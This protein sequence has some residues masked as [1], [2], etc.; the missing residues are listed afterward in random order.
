MCVNMPHDCRDSRMSLAEAWE[1]Q[2]PTRAVAG[3][4]PWIKQCFEPMWHI[5]D[6]LY[7]DRWASHRLGTEVKC[8]VCESSRNLRCL[9]CRL[10]GILRGLFGQ[11]PAPYREFVSS[12]P[13]CAAGVATNTILITGEN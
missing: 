5:Y 9:V 8:N 6:C 1:K 13:V 12:G 11:Q 7:R 4:V 10:I 3:G 2:V